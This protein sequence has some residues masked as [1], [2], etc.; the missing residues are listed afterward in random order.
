MRPPAW[1]ASSISSVA[2]RVLTVSMLCTNTSRARG[3]ALTFCGGRPV[4]EPQP[5]SARSPR[6][7]NAG[8]NGLGMGPPG[9]ELELP[10]LDQPVATGHDKQA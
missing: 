8:Q 7:A 5:V 2:S 6:A 4:G 10:A 1:A 9:F 3:A